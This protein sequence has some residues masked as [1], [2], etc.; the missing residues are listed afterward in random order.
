[1]RFQDYCKLE[2][3]TQ[4]E[5]SRWI[6]H[7]TAMDLIPFTPIREMD[8][9]RLFESMIEDEC[10]GSTLV[11]DKF[12]KAEVLGKN[13]N[14]A[15]CP[16]EVVEALSNGT[17]LN[18]LYVRKKDGELHG[19]YATRHA[20]LDLYQEAG[21]K[22]IIPA[23]I[24]N[25]VEKCIESAKLIKP[26]EHLGADIT[27]DRLLPNGKFQAARQWEVDGIAKKGLLDWYCD[28]TNPQI[29][30]DFKLTGCTGSFI[31]QLKSHKWVQQPHYTEGIEATF[32]FIVGSL[33]DPQQSGAV[34]LESDRIYERYEAECKSYHEWHQ[35]GR[36]PRGCRETETIKLY[37]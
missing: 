23:E 19:T 21:G 26:I 8:Y 12:L 14:A 28:I 33:E 30:L 25:K 6:Q 18:E 11:Q 1:M 17:D 36:K 22:T 32:I 37:L 16:N 10:T 34:I 20:W 5:L 13:G 4:S 7:R 24:W 9:G 29:V 31:R 2:G 35:S 3:I 27:L 15:E